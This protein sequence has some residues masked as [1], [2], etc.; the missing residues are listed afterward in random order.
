M[1]V[2]LGSMEG[3]MRDRVL[4]SALALV[5]ALWG[6]VP[7][8]ATDLDTSK[9]KKSFHRH[10]GLKRPPGPVLAVEIIRPPTCG[11]AWP[12]HYP[13]YKQASCRDYAGFATVFD[14]RSPDG[15]ATYGFRALY[16]LQ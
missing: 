8:A 7:A 15:L 16:G 12:F 5:L 4:C 11:V 14:P 13:N 10:L 2:G 9:P 3:R 1:G 6:A